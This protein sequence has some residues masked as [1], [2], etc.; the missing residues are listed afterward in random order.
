MLTGPR[1]VVRD[2]AVRPP[3]ESRLQVCREFM[4]EAKGY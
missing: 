1:A 3:S 2:Q 4:E